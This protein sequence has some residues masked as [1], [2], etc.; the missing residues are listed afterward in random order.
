L[1][2]GTDRWQRPASTEPSGPAAD[3]A[4]YPATGHRPADATST[5]PMSASHDAAERRRQEVT[6]RFTPYYRALD[7]CQQPMA[8]N[9]LSTLGRTPADPTDLPAALAEPPPGS[10]VTPLLPQLVN[11]GLV[12][13]VGNDNR[14]ALTD[15]GR[16]VLHHLQSFLHLVEQWTDAQMQDGVTAPAPGITP[17]NR[18]DTT[19]NDD[20][21]VPL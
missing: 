7:L 2:W 13:P 9:A 14:Y 5:N 12:A 8:L 6:N 1:A 17:Y 15:K 4:T 10:T 18:P 16:R 20:G 3:V 11:S 19:S 21:T